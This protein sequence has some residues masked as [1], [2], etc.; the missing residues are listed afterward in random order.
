MN[1]LMSN[2]STWLTCYLP[3]PDAR[4]RLICFPHGG[5]GPQSYRQWPDLFGE[6]VEVFA[7]HLP[8][9]GSRLRE[10]P[11]PDMQLICAEIVK[12]M[13]RHSDK[14]CA[15]FGHSV[16][17][18]IAYETAR[19]MEEQ[20]M[21]LPFLLFLSAHPAPH[22]IER[23]QQMHRF[24]DEQ[25]LDLVNSFGLIPGDGLARDELAELLL[26]S[27]RADFS[28]AE[29]YEL[30]AQSRIPIPM[31][32][33][34][35]SDD[36]MVSEEELYGWKEY[37]S[38]S[39]SVKLYAGGHFYYLDH[40]QEILAEMRRVMD[41][42]LAALPLSVIEG[43]RTDY[44][45]DKCLHQLFVDQA[46]KTP[47]KTALV[48]A[49]GSM[50]FRQLDEATDL[51]ARYLQ[52]QGVTVDTIT[53]IFMETCLDYVVAYL[54]ILKAGGAYMPL[55]TAFPDALLA[56]VLDST[57]PVLILTKEVWQARLPEAW[58]KNESIFIL[59][60]DW[61]K[62]LRESRLPPLDPRSGL[63][64]PDS[65]AFCIMSS[66]TTGMPKGII[67][68]HRS[69]VNSYYWRYSNYPYHEGERE[70][71]N[72]FF[73]WEVLRPLLQGYPAFIIAD[74][75]IYDPPGLLDFLEKY[76]I[77]RVLLTP[78]LLE[79]V[80]NT[81]PP[82]LASKLAALEIVYLNGE[83]VTAALVNDF[84]ARLP[85]VKLINDYS[86]TEC[87]DVCSCE[88]RDPDPRFQFVPVGLPMD[89]VRL[90]ILDEAL[91][92]VPKG[93]RGEIYVAGENL[94]RGYI[95]E[96]EKTAASFL[97]DTVQADGSLMYRT[98][99]FG[100]IIDND[101]LEVQGR[102]EFMIKLRGFSVV[103]GA[104]EATIAK[105][106]AVGSIAVLPENNPETG[107]PEYLVAY[108]VADRPSPELAAALR[109]H[110]RDHLPHYAVP[111]IFLFV[112]AL[113]LHEVTGKLDRQK[114]P[115]PDQAMAARD[116]ENLRLEPKNDLEQVIVNLWREILPNKP[117]AVTDNF[118]DL[119]GH[120]LLAIQMI[121]RVS[122][123]I[124][125]K[126]S[127]VDVF[128]YPTLEMFTQYVTEK[129]ATG[130]QRIDTSLDAITGRMRAMRKKGTT[131]EKIAIIGMACRFP[132]AADIRQY[133]E[134]LKNGVR[135]IRPLTENELKERGIPPKVYERNGYI[136][137]GALLDD[138]ESFDYRFWGLSRSEAILMDPQHRLFLECCWHACED[139]GCRPEEI[140]EVTGVFGGCFLPGY[141]VN[142]LG[143]GGL[144]DL[145]DLTRFHLTETGNDKD[146]FTSRVAYLM[147]LR[148]PAVT[149][150][151][152][153]STS[154]AAV[155]HACQA[156]SS[157]Q[158]DAAFAG[159]S[160]ITFPQGGYQ[161]MEG[162]INSPDGH[163]RAFDKD[164]GGTVFG[165]GVG[166][167]LLKR[168]ADAIADGDRVMATIRGIGINNDGNVKAGYSSP[169]V[170][171]QAE[172]VAQ[173]LAAAD[174][175]PENIS[176][177]EGHGTGTLIGDPIEVQALTRVFRRSTNEK[178]YCALGSVKP[179]IGHSNIAAGMAGL[180]KTVLSLQHRLIPPTIDYHTPNPEMELEKSP[181]YINERAIDWK[182]ANDL[183]RKAGVSCFGIGGT[184]VHLI[185]EEAEADYNKEEF[186][187]KRPYP[188]TLLPLSAK[189]TGSLDNA[190]KQ[191]IRFLK[192][193]PEYSLRDIGYTLG[194]G[195]KPFAKRLA[196]ACHDHASAISALS[197]WQQR[198]E[199]S[200]GITGPVVF[201]FSGQGSQYVGMAAQLYA[202]NTIFR[203]YADKCFAFLDDM[204][205][206]DLRIPLFLEPEK[207]A[208]I[209]E[210]PR[211]LQPALFLVEYAMAM[212]LIHLGVKP[213]M[214]MGHSIGEYAAAC[215]AGV[216]SLQDALRLVVFRSE[217]IDYADEGAMLSV[218]VSMQ[219]AEAYFA[220]WPDLT[221]AVE[222][223]PTDVVL[224]G[225]VE[226]ISKAQQECTLQG[227][228]SKKVN[229]TRAFHSPALEHGA[230]ILDQQA[231]D[232][233]FHAPTIDMTSNLT[234]EFLDDVPLDTTYWGRQMCSR[235]R[236]LQNVESVLQK[237]PAMM[238]EVGPGRILS[239]LV[240]RIADDEGF[241]QRSLK[242]LSTLPHPLEKERDDNRFLGDTLAAVWQGGVELDWQ[243]MYKGEKRRKISLP[244]YCFEKR[245]CWPDNRQ[246]LSQ[247]SVVVGEESETNQQYY[248][249]PSWSRTLPAPPQT[250]AIKPEES[251]CWW[252]YV[253]DSVVSR[254]L[255]ELLCRVIIS[256][257]R[258]PVCILTAN[259]HAISVQGGSCY[260]LSAEQDGWP[261][262]CQQLLAEG[263]RP[264][265][266][267][268]LASFFLHGDETASFDHY[269]HWL[270]FARAVAG[271]PLKKVH[272]Q[273]I[274]SQILQV[275]QEKI[276]PLKTSLLGPVIVLSQEYPHISSRLLDVQLFAIKEL[277]A[278]ADRIVDECLQATSDRERIVAIRGRNRWVARYEQIKLSDDAVAR[279]DVFDKPGSTYLITGG[280]GRI[281]LSLARYLA[282]R[283]C[284]LILVSR[285][286]C[287][288]EQRLSLEQELSSCGKAASI[289][290]EQ[291]DVSFEDEMNRVFDSAIAR[292]GRVDG[293]FH[294][295][296]VA[297][298]HYLH[299]LNETVSTEEFSGKVMGALAIERAIARQ[300]EKSGQHP[301]F[302]VLFSSLASVLGGL[303]MG[304]YAAANRCLDGLVEGFATAGVRWL[305][306]NWDDWD[307]AYTHE[308]TVFYEKTTAQ[309]AMSPEKG[310]KILE[311]ILA[312][313]H[314]SQVLVSTRP[315][316]PRIEKWLLEQQDGP[317]AVEPC[318][319][320]QADVKAA[321]TDPGGQ[322]S[323]L[324]T[325]IATVYR[326]VLG[327]ER[328]ET[329]DNF[330]DLGG[331]SLLAARILLGLRQNI[332]GGESIRLSSIFE[333]P[334]VALLAEAVAAEINLTDSNL[335][336]WGAG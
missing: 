295:A 125:L 138:V 144:T 75:I 231:A 23:H 147:G 104:V 176:Y 32:V 219:A 84:I 30:P 168:Y 55:E 212:T 298:L 190:R 46:R 101:C 269:Y 47:D 53:G 204:V 48:D 86:I 292:F 90:Y 240:R 285:R 99:D 97:P 158:C 15:F 286:I 209:F 195:R 1:L 22:F 121:A 311:E 262:L 60:R 324:E 233:A 18:L 194:V 220:A 112:D 10:P 51:L 282:A 274:T 61:Q 49:A 303:G 149:V 300:K 265:H 187:E 163:L 260:F 322:S 329:G 258:Q 71:C 33:L 167:I 132:G 302:V 222:N 279:A 73:V 59:G 43:A 136:R 82:D 256:L 217:A 74:E 118:F 131:G 13:A 63:I 2:L 34:G 308:Q 94:A 37:S 183:P 326:E 154:L 334:T 245:H 318:S 331:D 181:F 156:L 81:A 201:M 155:A 249:I 288:A 327:V 305:S 243:A 11:L 237:S 275:D 4:I 263:K 14:P 139:A 304:A 182:T 40:L 189:T 192:T 234:G 198:Q 50:T 252:V 137:F 119:G 79:Q 6:D 29:R 165:D 166:V 178:N 214:V 253:G 280:L 225:T 91:R 179:N 309:Y 56:R 62:K 264:D 247:N 175:S 3:R 123:I 102:A 278:I 174:V 128:H 271:L 66:G 68:P 297:N 216:V 257:G 317:A 287:S 228:Y 87:H 333:Y 291:A 251:P 76:R 129:K 208:D 268:H 153:C 141:L 31:M 335:R 160:S 193:H 151:T 172:V 126:L 92:P 12:S 242:V 255:A 57:E 289:V 277:P 294:T 177:V 72:V 223:S 316:Q 254:Q 35:G 93:M 161:Y 28:A 293:I 105:Y 205:A 306:I 111:S 197:A 210:Q 229:V 188:A 236:F 7:V 200:P 213:D 328:L 80:L 241:G 180:I 127:V 203:Q 313:P 100:R 238:L 330:F 186:S 164:A 117:Q 19:K 114:L 336:E 122:E 20:G 319:A 332:P 170:Q 221:I 109:Q 143:G 259:Q 69:A 44:P 169:S 5:G 148:G 244:T 116:E 45:A 323:R 157:G 103:L 196:V 146:Y 270:S 273:T 36:E 159:A 171:G 207:S 106:P 65:L 41:L 96:P 173:A 150:Q 130:S 142:V 162:F 250:T 78:S 267:I 54:A 239:H 296:G 290:I 218:Q 226:A 211:I 16:G 95:G 230:F 108:V 115:R 135:S 307:F 39:F 89:N 320:L 261:T 227:W 202:E 266:I 133:W 27:L 85:E 206:E 38:G 185:L 140:S 321:A 134:N 272:I 310:L 314:L 315:L 191:L 299:E 113:P 64:D 26:P 283:K 21:S 9:R 276:L 8:G 301:D 145:A 215:I 42:Q 110:A 77:S 67:C 248:Y 17:A 25:L 284:N 199:N 70:A 235:V 107:Q 232:I 120:S 52:K 312:H 152:S 83:V 325:I 58:Q 184:N 281:G 98:G 24:G 246:S 224:S 124:G 88:L